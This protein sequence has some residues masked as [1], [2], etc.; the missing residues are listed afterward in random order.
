[1]ATRRDQ[2][3]EETRSALLGVARRSFAR[4]GYADTTI[5]QIASRARVTHGALYHHF[6]G[7]Q[8]LFKAVCEDLERDLASRLVDAAQA[9][10]LAEGR[11]ERGCQA[12]L[13]ACM[14]PDFQRIVLLDAPSVLGWE[15]WHEMDSRY[16]L[17][18]LAAAIEAEIEAGR[19]A[20]QPVTPLAHAIHGA[21]NEAGHVIARAEDA[22]AAR[23]EMG[24]AIVSLIGS[25][26]PPLT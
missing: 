21:L 19:L 24:R 7:K 11:L 9:D 26:R 6:E 1:M 15:Q 23:A 2:R 13:D 25:L 20:P 10:R 12:F 4:A 14:E 18:L 8:A 16:G 3:S 17:A 5:G 22:P